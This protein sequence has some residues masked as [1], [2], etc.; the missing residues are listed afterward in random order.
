MGEFAALIGTRLRYINFAVLGELVTFTQMSRVAAE[1]RAEMS[2]ALDEDWQVLDEDMES[3][4][5]EW[6]RLRSLTRQQLT[7][8]DFERR[9][10]DT[11]IAA[12]ALAYDPPLPIVTAN[13][14]DFQVLAAAE[15]RLLLIHPDSG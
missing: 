13:L 2:A 9:Q 14:D 4:A 10:N 12:S 15:P 6:A 11:W 7:A 8:N 1:N 3:V 5:W